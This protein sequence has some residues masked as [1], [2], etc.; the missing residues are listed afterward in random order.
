MCNAQCPQLGANVVRKPI[1]TTNCGAIT[2]NKELLH[3]LPATRF[4]NRTQAHDLLR[5]LLLLLHRR[6]LN[7][8]VN[9]MVHLGVVH[10]PGRGAGCRAALVCG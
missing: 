4:V 10:K 7:S 9:V 5:V 6:K 2:P 3:N 1:W 8:Q